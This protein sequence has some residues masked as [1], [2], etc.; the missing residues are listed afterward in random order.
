MTSHLL[1][2]HDM[3]LFLSTLLLHDGRQHCTEY[4]KYQQNNDQ[5]SHPQQQNFFLSISNICCLLLG[6]L[7][8]LIQTTGFIQA[9]RQKLNFPWLMLHLNISWWHFIHVHLKFIFMSGPWTHHNETW[10]HAVRRLL[11]GCPVYQSSDR[12]DDSLTS[13]FLMPCDLP[14][15]P[16]RSTGRWRSTYWAPLLHINCCD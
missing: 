15:L 2:R 3:S 12:I 9:S 6:K 16:L 13:I 10:W 11:T 4:F 1:R 5:W 8:F 7:T 14:T